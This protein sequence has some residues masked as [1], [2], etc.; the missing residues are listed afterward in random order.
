MVQR[1]FGET[2][3][4]FGAHVFGGDGEE[5]VR[6]LA[7]DSQGRLY[8]A[9]SSNSWTALNAAN[10]SSDAVLFRTTSFELNP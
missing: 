1:R 9:G 3:V 6:D 4:W 5:D 7:R 10:G 2:G 8:V